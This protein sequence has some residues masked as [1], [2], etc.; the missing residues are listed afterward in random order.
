MVLM[1]KKKIKT[2]KE[3]RE[4][5]IALLFIPAKAEL[6]WRQRL[7]GVRVA[8]EADCTMEGIC[9]IGYVS[10]QVTRDPVT[11]VTCRKSAPFPTVNLG[12]V[13]RPL[14]LRCFRNRLIQRMPGRSRKAPA[15]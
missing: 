4:E 14:S 7:T 3:K 1:E 15:L 13:V 10:G 12:S 8:S 6:C 2:K 11:P 5:C 9:V